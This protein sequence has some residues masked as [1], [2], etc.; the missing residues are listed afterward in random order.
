MALMTAFFLFVAFKAFWFLTYCAQ[1]GEHVAQNTG[2]CILYTLILLISLHRNLNES[3]SDSLTFTCKNISLMSAHTAIMPCR[4]WNSILSSEGLSSGP[5][6]NCYAHQSEGDTRFLGRPFLL[7][8]LWSRFKAIS[9]LL[10]RITL[11]WLHKRA[12]S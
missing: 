2:T 5:F 8:L 7:F 12:V 10:G 1:Q 11:S 4:N 9:Q 3:S 6:S